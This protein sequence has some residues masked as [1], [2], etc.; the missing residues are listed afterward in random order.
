MTEE[1]RAYLERTGYAVTAEEYAEGWHY[2]SEFDGLLTQGEGYD[3]PACI[4][5]PDGSIA[6]D[7]EVLK[8]LRELQCVTDLILTAS[9]GKS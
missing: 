2:C 1:R 7:P 3:P 9:K 8:I 4:C 5:D 6:R